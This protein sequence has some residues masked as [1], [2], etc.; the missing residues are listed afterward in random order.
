MHNVEAMSRQ[1][2]G[3]QAPK[4]ADLPADFNAF[5]PSGKRLISLMAQSTASAT[6]ALHRLSLSY[7][8]AL[9]DCEL[10]HAWSAGD[11]GRCEEAFRS[12]PQQTP[13]VCFGEKS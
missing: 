13:S 7:S 4:I 6:P 10:M 12:R 1:P 9:Q 5:L 8:V 11:H 3:A 2:G